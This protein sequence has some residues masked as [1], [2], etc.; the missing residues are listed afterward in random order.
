MNTPDNP[1]SLAVTHYNMGVALVQQGRFHEAITHYR[2]SLR[3]DPDKAEAHNNLANVLQQTGKFEDAIASYHEALRCRPDCAEAYTNLATA[4]SELGRTEDA[5]ASYRQ[6]LR[7]KPGI[8]EI[9]NNLGL[10]LLEAGEWGEA[11][12]SFDEA[13][14]LNPNYAESR[15]N[16][17]LLWLLQGD[18]ARGWPEYDYRWTQP[19]IPPRKLAQ[20]LWDGSPLHGRTVLLYAE[21]GLGDTLQFIRYVPLV[22]A[23]GG[24]VILECQPALLRLSAGYPGVDTIIG[25]GSPL[26]AFDVQAPLLSVPRILKT[27]IGT[28][29]IAIPY[30]HADSALVE[31]WKSA[32][33]GVRSANS[34][35]SSTPYSLPRTPHFFIGIAWQGSPIYRYDR[36]RSIP[37]TQFAHLAAVPGVQLVSLQKGPGT[38]QSKLLSSLAAHPSPLAPLIDEVSGPFMDTTAIMKNLDLVVTSDTVIAHLAGA[39][40]VP[41]WVAL[42]LIPDWRWL[43]ERADSP[44][45]PGMRLFR[46]TRL[47]QWDDVFER[48]AAELR[49]FIDFSDP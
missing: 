26:P 12:E 42:P 35:L 40:G 6:A 10:T 33:F 15:W 5:I 27:S 45:Y 48:I 2:Q 24:K 37:L 49:Q 39:M 8:A 21:Q 28:I 44:W 47:G 9:W 41:V 43:L 17:S 20:P 19:T 46:Q 16:R 18:F 31:H 4:Q 3:F 25:Q 29:P 38:E 32:E 1:K 22:R 30:L 11:L 23:R 13:V 7:F 34:R 14:R 36:Q